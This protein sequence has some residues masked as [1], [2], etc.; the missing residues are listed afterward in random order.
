MLVEGPTNAWEADRSSQKVPLLYKKLVGADGRNRSCI[1]SCQ[2]DRKLT[3]SPVDAGKL[4]EGPPYAWKIDG[5]SQK[6]QLLQKTF[7]KGPAGTQ[8]LMEVNRSSR[9]RTKS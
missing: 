2:M 4:T 6:V 5:S 7:S 3:E 9:I 1:E 8:K